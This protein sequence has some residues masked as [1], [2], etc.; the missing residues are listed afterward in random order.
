MVVTVGWLVGCTSTITP[1]PAPRDPVS[2]FL[3]LDDRHRGVVM[4]DAAG[5]GMVEFGYGDWDWYAQNHDA[6]YDV[7]DTILWPTTGTIGRRPTDATSGQDLRARYPWIELHEFAVERDAMVALRGDLES[8][9]AARASE[10]HYNARYRMT[11]VP[12]D[13]GYWCLFNCNDAVADWLERLGC[14]VSW[15]PI[16]IGLQVAE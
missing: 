6:W 5:T 9:F 12:V 15:V 7:F 3:V 8:R 2:V 11:F 10:Q 1:P 16:R 13:D 4:Q 14:S